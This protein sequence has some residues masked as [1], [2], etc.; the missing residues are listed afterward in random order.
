MFEHI[1]VWAGLVL[2]A[3]LCLPFAGVQKLVLEVSAW[4][5]RL[6]LLALVAAA[7]VLWARPELLPAEAASLFDRL[8]EV[9]AIFP[10]P[11]SPT[12]G[13]ALAGVVILVLLPLLAV[14]DV[15]RKLAG[16]RL[17]RL[18]A[19]TAAPWG[20]TH[21]GTALHGTPASAAAQAAG[22]PEG[23]QR[24][25]GPA[26]TAARLGDRRA[27]AETMASVSSQKPFRVSDHVS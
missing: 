20:E 21:P 7:G 17:R 15:A 18:R 1:L 22:A 25:A 9:R 11:G 19:L 4:V 8:P 12:F 6:A 3:L 26:N 24:R 10:E 13:A 2:L 23:R 14:L 5:L 16:Q 27:A